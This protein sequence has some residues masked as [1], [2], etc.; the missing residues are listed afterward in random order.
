MEIV[1]QDDGVLRARGDLHISEAE[2][3]KAALLREL[4]ASPAV[5][6]DLSDVNSCD[7]AS[8]QLL[9]SLRKSAER[10]GKQ[11]RIA[12]RSAAV[13]EECA[14][15]GISLEELAVAEKISEV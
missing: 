8:F 15:L 7:A 13:R 3:L 2:E 12:A 14:I 6:L 1:R 5:V 11:Y 9:C 4:A 10:D